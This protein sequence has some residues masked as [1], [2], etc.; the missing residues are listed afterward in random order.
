MHHL[1]SF[2]KMNEHS[3]SDRCYYRSNHI[4][5]TRVLKAR[6]APEVIVPFKEFCSVAGQ[7]N[8]LGGPMTYT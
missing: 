3:K 2:I 4:I 6:L 1:V 5:R 8:V 7:I